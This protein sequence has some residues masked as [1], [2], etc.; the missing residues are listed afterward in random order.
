MSGKI[1]SIVGTVRSGKSFL[2]HKLAQHYNVPCFLEGED[3]DIPPEIVEGIEK[4][5]KTMERL[6]FFRNR[7]I[8]QHLEAL[9]LAQ[10]HR[11]IFLDTAWMSC[12]PY[13]E[14]A[15]HGL[16]RTLMEE[17]ASLDRKLLP[18][19]DAIIH[20]KTSAAAAKRFQIFGGRSWDGSDEYFE[21]QYTKML[22]ILEEF[23]AQKHVP[24]P[25]HEVDRSDLDF[26]K[27]EDLKTVTD[28][29]EKLG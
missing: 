18:W 25:I 7:F 20:L 12:I 3:E 8:K 17:L 24:V 15:A 23:F 14:Q 26:E 6:I 16:Q 5:T 19:P 4:N 11:F 29:V 1:V 2:T 27:V 13:I 22:P 21:R 9:A 10:Q 28:L